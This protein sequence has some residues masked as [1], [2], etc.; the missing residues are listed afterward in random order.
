[1]DNIIFMEFLSAIDFLNIVVM[2]ICSLI[3][4]NY[5]LSF[6]SMACCIKRKKSVILH[7]TVILIYYYIYIRPISCSH[8]CCWYQR[9]C[10]ILLASGNSAVAGTSS[11][12]VVP[13]VSWHPCCNYSNFLPRMN[14]QHC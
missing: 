9:L 4:N 8:P 5:S 12:A 1:M 11:I 10:M 14:K 7:P 3:L 13:A 6:S 2:H